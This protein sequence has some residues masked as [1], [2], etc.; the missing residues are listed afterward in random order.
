MEELDLRQLF[1]FDERIL[2]LMDGDGGSAFFRKL[3]FL[4]WL[5]KKSGK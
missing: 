1:I 5:Y 3:T 2:E 4:N